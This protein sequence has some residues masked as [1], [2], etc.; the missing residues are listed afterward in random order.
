MLALFLKWKVHKAHVQNECRLNIRHV[1]LS[2]I[3]KI[4]NIRRMSDRQAQAVFHMNC[5]ILWRW[6][7]RMPIRARHEWRDEDCNH[8][9]QAASC[10]IDV[11][12]RRN[13]V[14]FTVKTGSGLPFACLFHLPC[15]KRAS[16]KTRL[17]SR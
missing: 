12:A 8:G 3:N 9:R 5:K 4:S 11:G 13:S 7:K 16:D 1:R 6:N 14:P 10:D 2:V 17:G 15:R